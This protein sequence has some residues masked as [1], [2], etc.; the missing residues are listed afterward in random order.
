MSGSRPIGRVPFVDVI[1]REVYEDADGRQ[2]V[3]GYD[4]ERVYGVCLAP[5][6]EPVIVFARH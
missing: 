3:T 2:W 4:G 6:G 1:E 5:A